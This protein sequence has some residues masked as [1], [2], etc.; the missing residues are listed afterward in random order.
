MLCYAL[1]MVSVKERDKTMDDKLIYV[2]NNKIKL[3][4][5]RVSVQC[6][7]PS[8]ICDEDKYFALC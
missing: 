2:P 1:I 6:P 5:L 3:T 7:L 8:C 4:K